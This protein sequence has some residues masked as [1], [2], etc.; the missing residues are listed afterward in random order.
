[1]QIDQKEM[2]LVA[3]C[4]MPCGHIEI[5]DHLTTLPPHRL[6]FEQQLI[7]GAKQVIILDDARDAEYRLLFN[8]LQDKR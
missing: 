1:M 6:A 4:I 2:T 5:T 3:V 8:S 7:T